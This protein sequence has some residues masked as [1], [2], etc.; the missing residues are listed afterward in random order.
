MYTSSSCRIVTTQTL[1]L[2]RR[3]ILRCSYLNGKKPSRW[4]KYGSLLF[5]SKISSTSNNVKEIQGDLDNGIFSTPIRKK[6]GMIPLSTCLSY[7]YVL[8][9]R[10]HFLHRPTCLTSYTWT[11]IPFRSLFIVSRN[12]KTTVI[13]KDFGGKDLESGLSMR[14]RNGNRTNRFWLWLGTSVVSYKESLPTVSWGLR[15]QIVE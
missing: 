4:S 11:G 14:V 10:G 9:W 1:K 8:I 2:W 15:E 6:E 5:K 7:I 13:K 3:E 12:N